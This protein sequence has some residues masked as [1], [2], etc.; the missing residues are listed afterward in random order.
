MCVP[1]LLCVCAGGDG[2]GAGAGGHPVVLPFAIWLLVSAQRV[3]IP[4]VAEHVTQSLQRLRTITPQTTTTTHLN[5]ISRWVPAGLSQHSLDY[6]SNRENKCDY[7]RRREMSHTFTTIIYDWV[8]LE[9][10]TQTPATAAVRLQ[11]GQQQKD[12][13]CWVWESATEWINVCEKTAYVW[14][15][16]LLVQQKNCPRKNILFSPIDLKESC[17]VVQVNVQL[18]KHLS[19]KLLTNRERQ[20]W[21]LKWCFQPRVI[22]LKADKEMN[23]DIKVDRLHLSFSFYFIFL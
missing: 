23:T 17:F 5:F 4:V 6:K 11:S 16:K 20:Q 10:G 2:G 18:L 9:Q 1:H 12:W 8:V 19:T 21:M 14:A 15:V 7:S 13:L 3:H 22:I